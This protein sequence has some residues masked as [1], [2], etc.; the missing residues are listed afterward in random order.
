MAKKEVPITHGTDENG[1]EWHFD[2]NLKLYECEVCGA[3]GP[4]ADLMEID[5]HVLCLKC[6]KRRRDKA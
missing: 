2:T 5:N 4:K 6:W 3:S 1:K